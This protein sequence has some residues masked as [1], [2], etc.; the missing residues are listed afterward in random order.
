MTD[1]ETSQ[2]FD[3]IF[4][5]DRERPMMLATCR[6][7]K[8]IG[9]IYYPLYDF[10]VVDKEEF[11]RCTFYRSETHDVSLI[12][13]GEHTGMCVGNTYVQL[14]LPDKEGDVKVYEGTGL[15]CVVRNTIFAS[16]VSMYDIR[17][18]IYVSQC[19]VC[20]E[21]PEAKKVGD[22]I[23]EIIDKN[24]DVT[25]GQMYRQLVTWNGDT[26]LVFI[27]NAEGD[28]TLLDYGNLDPETL[29]EFTLTNPGQRKGCDVRFSE[30]RNIGL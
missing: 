7:A 22:K 15:L 21:N 12:N 28:W 14:G 3:A 24:K 29:E 10:V 30:T 17:H 19:F 20:H 27:Y 25:A 26:S 2:W 18:G 6:N 4:Y 1:K 16:N 23:R 5:G 13:T 11:E 9:T 8:Q